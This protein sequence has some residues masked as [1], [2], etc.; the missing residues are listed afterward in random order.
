MH[1]VEH[2]ISH[3]ASAFLF[4]PFKQVA[5]LS[6]D[7]FGNFV[8]TMWGAGKENHIQVKDR[9]FI[10]PAAGDAGGCIGAAYHVWHQEL[11]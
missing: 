8:G 5:V 9:I 6:V 4:S 2:H 10:Q 11:G 7:G 1:Y 3:L